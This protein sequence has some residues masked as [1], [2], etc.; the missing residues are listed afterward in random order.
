MGLDIF[1]QVNNHEEVFH[2]SY[3]KENHK[4][5]LSR[6]FC[7]FICRPGVISHKPEL[8]QIGE[9]TGLDISPL[10]AMEEYP[11]DE[12]FEDLKFITNIEDRTRRREQ[13]QLKRVEIQNNLPKV[14]QLVSRLI[15]RLSVVKSLNEKLIK[16][17][18]ETLNSEYYFSD[19][20]RDKGDGYLRNNFGQDL[21][22]FKNYLDYVKDR[23]AK[24]VWFIYG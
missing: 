2:K 21:R 24:T 22:N 9:I 13:L 12:A 17:D 18:F 8:D 20:N 7:N 19:F 3:Y 14:Y 1:L 10:Y 4:H 15:E 23:G 11:D 5:S 6:E 16:T